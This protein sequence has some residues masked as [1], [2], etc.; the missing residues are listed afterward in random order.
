[1]RRRTSLVTAVAATALLAGCGLT[2]D[3][4]EPGVAASVDGE[5]VR[6]S[7]VDDTVAAFCELLS[8]E[9]GA[10]VYARASVRSQLAWNWAQAVAV[11]RIAG[12]Y[13]VDL[14]SDTIDPG[15]V[16]R[17]WRLDDDVDDDTFD[18]FEWLTAIQLRLSDPLLAIGSKELVEKTGQ[19]GNQDAALSAGT[20]VVDAWLTEHDVT[21]NPTLGTRD[22]KT[23][24][25]LGDDLSVAVSGAAKAGSDLTRLTIEQAAALPATARC[26][27][28][29]APQAQPGA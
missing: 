21:L 12:D 19:P 20:Q 17:S 23:G 24:G 7:R 8:T 15:V 9:D 13:G 5:S 6:L 11:E 1:M 3:A 25:F 10:P 27:A 16:K 18:A 29:S 2:D 4:P 26:G 22:A 14:P 28:A